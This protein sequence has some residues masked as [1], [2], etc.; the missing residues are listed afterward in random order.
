MTGEWF[1]CCEI[2]AGRVKLR[3]VVVIVV[4]EVRIWDII[5]IGISSPVACGKRIIAF[6]EHAQRQ[7]AIRVNARILGSIAYLRYLWNFGQISIAS[8]V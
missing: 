4:G 6:R 5:D 3:D 7:L 1:A 8:L 2:V